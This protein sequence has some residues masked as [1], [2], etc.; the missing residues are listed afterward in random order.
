MTE[1]IITFPKDFV[2]GGATASFQIEGAWNEDGKSEN[3][4]DRFCRIPGKVEN[5]DTGD[6]ACDH[7]HRWKDDINIMKEIGLQAYRFSTSW[8]RILPEGRGKINQKGLYFYNQ[9][10]D[11]LLEAGIT[12]Y[13]TLYHWDMPQVLQ[14][15]G[16]WPS[17]DII[18]AFT[19]YAD[20]VSQALGDRVK[21]WTT[22]NEPWVVAFLGYEIGMHAPGHKNTQEALQA[23]H[24]LLL[25]HAD[26]MPIIRENSA[27]SKV[28]IVL[29]L[30]PQEPAS[31]SLADRKAANWVDG[32]INRWFLDPLHG[33]GYPQD[34]VTGHGC[35]MSFIQQGDMD[36]I[37]SPIDYLG[38]N[39][40]TRN[41]ARN[42]MIPEE[43][44][45]PQ[46]VF[47]HG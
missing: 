18:S 19:E 29:N 20:V 17:R 30:T 44:K 41:I 25:S 37:F 6:V 11:G 2:W 13:L 21:H 15:Q 31:P 3:I 43:E 42:D 7:Y 27:D 24:H 1:K 45:E 32:Y 34:I 33:R 23:A 36:K 5:G 40:Y 8:G 14:D 12:P 28:G 26:A 9:L 47:S 22:F 39:Y 46:T 10:V 4:W 38:V 35:D 16:G